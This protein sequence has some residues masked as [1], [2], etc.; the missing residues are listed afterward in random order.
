MSIYSLSNI[1]YINYFCL[2]GF[3]LNDSHYDGVK[4]VDSTLIYTRCFY[5]D[6]HHRYIMFKTY[7]IILSHES[8]LPGY[9]R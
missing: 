8:H 7:A 3:Y 9:Q 1:H 2:S 6:F 5:C 4:I